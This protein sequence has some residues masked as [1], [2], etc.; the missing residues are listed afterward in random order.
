MHCNRLSTSGGSAEGNIVRDNNAPGATRNV[1]HNGTPLMAYTCTDRILS[2]TGNITNN[3]LFGA[4]F[5]LQVGS[6]CI[7]AGSPTAPASVDLNG[8]PRPLDGDNDGTNTVDMGCYEFISSVADSD[9][10]AVP[11]ADEQIAD[12]GVLDSNDWFRIT[13]LDGNTVSFQSSDQRLYRLLWSTN[14]V[15]GNWTPAAPARMGV[16]GLD[17]MSGTN[18]VPA[19]FYKLEVELP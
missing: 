4:S 14:L 19:E 5:Q 9:G 11:D 3:P 8:I 6:P 7:D 18:S 1:Y 13:G 15:E 12:T 10:D 16:S 17:Y 2:G